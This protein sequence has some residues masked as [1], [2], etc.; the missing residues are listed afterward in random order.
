MSKELKT[1][2]VAV[3]IIAVFIWG[4][5]FLKGQDL[6]SG[7]SR[8]FYVEYKD[9][10]GLNKASAVTING[11]EVGRIDEISF[12]ATP[13]KQGVLL[14]KISLDTDFSFSKNSI[15]KIYSA[16]IM[17]G[18]SLAIVPTYSGETA[19]SGDYLKGEVESG[20]FSSVE[21]KLEP[22]QSKLQNVLVG[23]DTLL[24]GLNTVLD[25]KSRK[26]LNRSI[27][28]LEGTISDVRKTLTSVNTLLSDNKENL[29]ATLANTK[30]ITD[31][32]SK[33]SDDLAKANLGE[34]VNK[35]EA[36]LANVNGLLA[37]M[38]AGKGTLGKLMTDDKMYTNLTNASKEMEELLREM[39]LNPK[40]FVHFSLFGKKAKP[41]NEES[42]TKNVST[43]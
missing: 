4:F 24:T 27:I 30:K 20:L 34:T 32:F 10:N 8:Y 13:E 43:K 38:K 19:V 36:T 31:N 7:S 12:D 3:L 37:N 23:A 16:S 29:N 5:N 39:K 42:N 41:Y 28:G 1:G 9:I 6:F 21:D 2:V 35:L 17:G 33:I 26:S 40:R 25:E 18:Q 14:V 11:L 22:I 15:A